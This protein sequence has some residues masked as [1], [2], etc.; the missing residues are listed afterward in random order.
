MAGVR[1]S[2]IVRYPS[3]RNKADTTNMNM[4]TGLEIVKAILLNVVSHVNEVL[5]LAKAIANIAKE[6]RLAYALRGQNMAGDDDSVVVKGIYVDLLC[7]G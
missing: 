2:D 5:N 4:V 3:K 6:G 7:V 1:A